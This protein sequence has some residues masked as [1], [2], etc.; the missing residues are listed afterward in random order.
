MCDSPRDT[1]PLPAEITRRILFFV[2]EPTITY[3]GRKRTYKY[4][5]PRN[6]HHPPGDIKNARLVCKT[7]ADLG[8]EFL[9]QN[10]IISADH[11]QLEHVKEI[12][13]QKRL[14]KAVRSLYYDTRTSPAPSAHDDDDDNSIS[15]SQNDQWGVDKGPH[16]QER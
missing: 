13:E 16:Q 1:L 3:D 14:C 5:R 10:L 4:D 9:F 6:L 12:A 11:R 8:A 7:F 15:D 2:S